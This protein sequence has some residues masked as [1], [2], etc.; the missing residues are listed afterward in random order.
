MH[1]RAKPFDVCYL[2][3]LNPKTTIILGRGVRGGGS[4]PVTSVA[5]TLRFRNGKKM[6]EKFP[7]IFFGL[8]VWGHGASGGVWVNVWGVWVVWG[9]GVGQ[10][11]G[12]VGVCGG[13]GQGLGCLLP[14]LSH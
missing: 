10:G 1:E 4:P 12:G 5:R 8:E 13:V 14:A 6:K 2:L 3:I 11:L 7:Q 9:G